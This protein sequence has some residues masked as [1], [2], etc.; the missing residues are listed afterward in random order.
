M[1]HYNADK[2]TINQAVT[3]ENKQRESTKRERDTLECK[4]PE[5]RRGIV[6]ICDSPV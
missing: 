1:N 2:Y 5:S 3:N 4:L 6:S